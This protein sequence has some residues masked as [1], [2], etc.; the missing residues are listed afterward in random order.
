MRKIT[1]ELLLT[2]LSDPRID[3]AR[4]SVTRV[5]VAEDLLTA[6]VYISVMG[7]EGRQNRTL[8]ALRHAS[9]HI[10]ELIMR[11]MSLRTTPVLS[12]VADTEFKKTI[13]T[14]NIIQRVADEIRQKDE[15]R[16]QAARQASQDTGDTPAGESEQT[17]PPGSTNQDQRS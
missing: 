8:Q 7:T 5:E 6:K 2:K 1:G 14:L 4:T 17:P 16:L 9:G 15:A 11:Q 13:E 12:F 3:R 10:Q